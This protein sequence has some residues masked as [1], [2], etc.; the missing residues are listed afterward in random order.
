M[1]STLK[2]I[3]SNCKAQSP[4]ARIQYEKFEEFWTLLQ[5]QIDA[6]IKASREDAD[7]KTPMPEVQEKDEFQQRQSQNDETEDNCAMTP[8]LKEKMIEEYYNK[9]ARDCLDDIVQFAPRPTTKPNWDE[10]LRN[11]CFVKNR[12]DCV[13]IHDADLDREPQPSE[14]QSTS[15]C[16][17]IMDPQVTENL[18]TSIEEVLYSPTC[19]DVLLTL[20][21]KIT[22]NPRLEFNLT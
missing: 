15:N 1:D 9:H 14:R 2:E 12:G 20:F 13:W 7:A 5:R 11:H 22:P 10:V 16:H 21:K 19:K 4:Q 3:D 17:C 18:L 6:D 8:A